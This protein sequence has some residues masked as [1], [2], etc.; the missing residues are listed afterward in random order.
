MRRLAQLLNRPGRFKPVHVD[1]APSSVHYSP[2]LFLFTEG[3]DVDYGQ[4]AQGI[5]DEKTDKP[6]KV[7]IPACPPQGNSLPRRFPY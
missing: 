1:K 2:L 6:G 7:G 4:Y 5:K 3:K